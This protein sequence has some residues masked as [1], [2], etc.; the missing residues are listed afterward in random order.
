MSDHDFELFT[1]LRYDP[2]LLS[3]PE[4]CSP[5]LSFQS[6]SP[7]YMLVYH[8]DRML[9]AAR[10]FDWQKVADRLQNGI[11][12]SN[13][14]LRHV[15]EY[16]KKNEA[17]DGPLKIKILFDDQGSLGTEL[18]PI[19][20]VSLETLYPPSLSP[21]FN[22]PSSKT[23]I[24]DTEPTHS[25][26]YTSLKTT[27]RR[28]YDSARTRSLR[29]T[30]DEVLLFNECDEITEGTMTSVYLFKG[31][32]WVTP[33]VGVPYGRYP[34]KQATEATA[35][36]RR[37]PFPGRWGHSVRSE[38]SGS[39]GQRGTTRRWALTKALCIEEV[40]GRLSLSEGEG[41]WISNGVRGFKYGYITLQKP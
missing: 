22:P 36:E 38:Y 19:P 6:P 39:G 20:S 11:E 24:L 41:A 29:A 4:N 15:K 18:S 26:S 28:H 31:G 35:G 40:T 30:A 10:H 2:L 21:P 9:E 23:L 27:N 5:S 16:Q 33:P 32:R 3:S 1:S 25:S 14:L 8:R 17:R 37:T 13:T 12:L 7:F 34:S